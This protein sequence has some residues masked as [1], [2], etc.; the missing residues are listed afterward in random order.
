M[1]TAF[2]AGAVS[3]PILRLND[4]GKVYDT[5]SVAVE[6]LRGVSLQVERGEYVAIMGPSGS[7]KSTLMHILGCLDVPTTGSYDLAGEDVST[8]SEAAL[9]NVRNR[10]IGF[11]FQQF[12]LLPSLPAWRNVELPLCYTGMARAE[13]KERAIN[14]LE[15]VGLGDRIEH[16]PGEL[17][18]GQQQ[19]VAVARAL[20]TDPALILADEPTGNLDSH[21]SADVLALFTELH[22]QGR[23]IVLIT[24]ERDVAESAQRIV[25]ILDGQVDSALAMPAGTVR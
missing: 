23:T 11:V 8:M 3:S 25:R 20:V 22:D 24:H 16:R 15:R 14:A 18:G 1:T 6:A 10:Q 9:A 7:G 5:G 12:N 13:R 21:S 19:R 4:V 17:S 2:V